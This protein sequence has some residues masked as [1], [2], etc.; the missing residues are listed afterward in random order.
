MECTK[1]YRSTQKYIVPGIIDGDTPR[2]L[3]HDLGILEEG[4]TTV[5]KPV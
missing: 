3:S 2:E 5:R 1:T 4:G